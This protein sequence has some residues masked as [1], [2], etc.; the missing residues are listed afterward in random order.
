[1]RSSR[2]TSSRADAPNIVHR[3]HAVDHLGHPPAHPAVRRGGP[4][5]PLA[6]RR[7]RLAR[8]RHPRGLAGRAGRRRG[9]AGGGARSSRR[10]SRASRSS[11]T[12]APSTSP[13]SLADFSSHVPAL[14]E[15]APS[16]C[17]RDPFAVPDGRGRLGARG[18]R[19]REGI[20]VETLNVPTFVNR[21]VVPAY[22]QGTCRRAARRRRPAEAVRQRLGRSAAIRRTRRRGDHIAATAPGSRAG[23]RRAGPPLALGRRTPVDALGRPVVRSTGGS[24]AT[25]SCARCRGPCRGRPPA[26]RSEPPLSAALLH[27][28]LDRLSGRH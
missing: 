26:N 1:M 12:R 24:H 27:G 19:A 7:R 9:L 11:P 22:A 17:L 8:S 5:R 3:R 13:E 16:A 20:A 10:S 23:R 6:R 2:R 14:G 18:R 4:A 15:A 21:L 28:T 25:A